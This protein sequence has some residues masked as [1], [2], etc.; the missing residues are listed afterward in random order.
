[1]AFARVLEWPPLNPVSECQLV[2]AWHPVGILTVG[3]IMRQITDMQGKR[4]LKT[5]KQ[6][7]INER[8]LRRRNWKHKVIIDFSF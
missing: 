2:R 6:A 4:I 5:E 1:M 8:G 7:R 3:L